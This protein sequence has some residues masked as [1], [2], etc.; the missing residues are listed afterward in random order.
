MK[1]LAQKKTCKTCAH[2]DLPAKS[3]VCRECWNYQRWKNYKPI[4]GGVQK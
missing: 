1:Q 3:E 4:E 2:R